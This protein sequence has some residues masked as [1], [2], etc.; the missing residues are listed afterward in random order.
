MYDGG[1]KRREREGEHGGG[2]LAPKTMLLRLYSLV[3]E[4]GNGRIQ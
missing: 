2:L 3:E 1:R 4:E